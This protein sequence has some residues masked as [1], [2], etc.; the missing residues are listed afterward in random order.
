MKVPTPK[1][2]SS[3]NWYINLRLGGESISVTEPTE[4]SCIRAA[5]LIKAEYLAGKRIAKEKEDSLTLT[6]AIDRYITS[7]ENVLSPATIRGYRTIQKNRFQSI[8]DKPLTDLTPDFCQKIINNE[9]RLC[10]SKTLANSWRFI[11]S[12]VRDVTGQTIRVRL[13]Q[14]VQHE[15]PFLDPDQI[16]VFV[17]AV[18]GSDIEVPALL[19]LCSLRTSEIRGLRWQD[20]DFSRSIIHVRSAIVY[21]ENRVLVHKETT[22]NTTSRR[23]VPMMPQLAA[24]LKKMD[25]SGDYIVPGSIQHVYLQINK[26]CKE[27]N[28][29]EVGLHGLRHSFASLA[30]HLGMPSKIAQEIGG[31]ADDATMQRI[32]THIAQTDRIT[33]QNKML[34]YYKKL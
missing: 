3:G 30:Y 20:V 12:V 14:V 32:Y 21:D 34:D 10:S 11:S 22:K 29:P 28:L 19:A 15:R 1:K 2:M 33:N 16:S 13:P 27:N 18:H 5:Q 24:A 17:S 25:R 26:I 4:K 6:K 23:D 9:T 8:M 31:W 7:R